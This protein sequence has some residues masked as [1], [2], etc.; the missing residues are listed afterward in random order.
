MKIIPGSRIY[1]YLA[2]F[3]VF[4]IM[5]A[6]IAGMVGCAPPPTPIPIGDW[7]DLDAVRDNLGDS[8]ILVND[9]DST[10]AG[11]EELASPTANQGKGW[12][13]IGTFTGTFDG[14]EY[15]IHDLFINRPDEM[16][17]G[18][19]GKIGEGACIENIGV[20]TADVNGIE[21][22]G[23]LVGYNWRGTVNNCHATGTVVSPHSVGGLVGSN[24]GNV[25]NSWSTC[26]VTCNEYVAGGLVGGNSDLAAVNNC[27]STGDVTGI[28]L[29]GGL[30]GN[31]DGTVSNSYASGTVVGITFSIGG[32][33]GNNGHGTVINCYANC[34]V[35]GNEEVGGL[36]GYNHD[37]ISNSYSTGNV[38]GSD[39][40]GGLLG[41]NRDGTVS[42]SYSTGSVIGDVYVG[43]LVGYNEDT[44]IGSFWD[45]E[46]SGQASSDGGT[47]KN[48]TEM[49][50]IPTFSL[51]GWNIIAVGDPATPNPAYI[52][53]IPTT[54]P[55]YPFLSW[56]S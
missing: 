18:L 32:L 39:K 17:V 2:R 11:Y 30:V 53:N 26:T 23:A 15:E 19:F 6:L 46:T 48:T 21:M 24:Y 40:V 34:S 29:I 8:Y 50:S 16:Y 3:G 51:A 44:V 52:W 4:L 55:D 14:Q 38:A 41:W 7:Y 43:G 28:R 35:T 45:I 1:R 13:P 22:V 56:Q 47:G 25:S 54:P 10:T 37:T 5:A 31:N 33:V 42:N 9:L 36:V 49:Q 12:Q 20:L 27:S